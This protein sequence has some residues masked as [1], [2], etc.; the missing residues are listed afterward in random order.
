MKRKEIVSSKRIG[1]NTWDWFDRKSIFS[2]VWFSL[3]VGTG[4]SNYKSIETKM[5]RL[6]IEV[7]L[8]GR[9]WKVVKNIKF[10]SRDNLFEP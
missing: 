10:S 1:K 2:T 7:F 5:K 6:T 9:L 3:D 4:T 8:G